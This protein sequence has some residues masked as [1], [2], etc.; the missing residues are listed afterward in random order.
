MAGRVRA[1]AACGLLG[2]GLIA[3]TVSVG[4]D[5]I[6]AGCG[7]E[8]EAE[9]PVSYSSGLTT[10][11]IYRSSSW[12]PADWVDFPP[13]ATV[14]FEHALGTEP[15]AWQA[16]VATSR[17]GDGATLVLAT[18][19][20]VELVGIDDEAVTVHNGTCVDFF[21]VVVAMASVPT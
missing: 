2:V 1:F 6:T 9:P 3:A 19:N 20:D 5:V 10:N 13:G 4:C 12:E 14:R 16:Y 21:V 8:L 11:G 15:L 7:A 17:D 18:G